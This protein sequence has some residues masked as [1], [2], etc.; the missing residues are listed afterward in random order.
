MLPGPGV[1]A[2]GETF[3][4][5]VHRCAVREECIQAAWAVCPSFMPVYDLPFPVQD[6]LG[7]GW[8]MSD[9]GH[10]FRHLRRQSLHEG[11]HHTGA[12]VQSVCFGGRPR[13]D[14]AG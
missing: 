1:L 5:A 10:L 7:A 13:R 8:D 4:D 11:G 2:I 6:G 14:R 12:Q 3:Q 9:V